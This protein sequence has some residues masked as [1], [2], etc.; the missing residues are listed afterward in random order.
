MNG[1]MIVGWLIVGS[2]SF[3]FLI[4]MMVIFGKLMLL[5]MKIWIL[6]KRG[7]HL[8]E[9]IGNNRVRNYYYLKP[10]NNKFD[11]K[12][13]FYLHYPETTTKTSQLLPSSPKGWIFKK[14]S[15]EA[16]DEQINK[17]KEDI[18]KLVYDSNAVTL[19]W[20]IPIITYVG[21]NPNPINFSEPEK[22]Y[23]AQVIRDVYIRLLATAQFKDLKRIITLMLI[24]MGVTAACL[25]ALYFT[26]KQNA[27]NLGSCLA[28]FN[29]TITNLMHCTAEKATI[30]AQNST[31]RI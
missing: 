6:A 30:L 29:S 14:I 23:G 11:F 1:T 18:S 7:F 28:T 5:Q 2:A 10:S 25:L 17:L 15:D 24:I 19:R 31:V 20:G 9:H 27:S 8:V 12:S 4:G 16:N 21:N 26:Y 22:E 3:L 13:G